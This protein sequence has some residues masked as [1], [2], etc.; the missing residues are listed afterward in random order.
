MNN[1]LNSIQLFKKHR[2]IDDEPRQEQPVT[3]VTKEDSPSSEQQIPELII[4]PLELKEKV[5]SL[6][7]NSDQP[8]FSPN[9][10]NVIQTVLSILDRKD[11]LPLN[12]FNKDIL[13]WP[14][15][16]IFKKLK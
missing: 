4:R 16:S 10:T 14:I 7:S 13:K 8:P 12:L 6:L 9:I 1:N 2:E 15:W 11:N 5:N 3:K